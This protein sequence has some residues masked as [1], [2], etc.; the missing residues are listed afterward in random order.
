VVA[1]SG[2]LGRAHEVETLLGGAELLRNR[3]EIVFLL[4]GGGIE[5]S[6]LA[7]E[8]RYRKLSNFLFKPYQPRESLSQSLG[9]GDIHWL[10]LK[11]GMN[12]LVLPSKFYGIAAGRPVIVIGSPDGE[13]SR[14]VVHSDCGFHIGLG[15]SV[16]LAQAIEILETDQPRCGEMGLNARRLLDLRFAKAEALERWR[17]EL[18]AVVG[19]PRRHYLAGNLNAGSASG[20]AP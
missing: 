16:E 8:V 7:T 13:L 1:Y 19:N 5:M 11:T 4:I 10:S 18:R 3:A 20:D 6:A 17:T 2:N 15:R 9:V 12:G 14:L